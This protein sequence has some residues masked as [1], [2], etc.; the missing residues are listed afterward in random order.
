[1]SFYLETECPIDFSFDYQEIAQKVITYCLKRE[2][3]PYEAE[4]N[5]TLT[6]NEGI[7][8]IN[9]AY[10]DIDRPTD[11]LSF[12]MLSYDTPGDFSFLEEESDDNFN[13]DTGEAILGDI[14]ISVE[15]VKE[16][17]LEYGHSELRE[18]AFLI[19]HSMLHLFGYDH[20]EK[21]EADIM[22][23]LQKQILEE[24][25]ILR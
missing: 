20:M 21:E 17:A 9:K 5:L 25:Q 16:Q 1:M 11:V 22:E 13:P 14:I 2:K 23:N 6:D 8:Q 18:Y 12:P 7:W 4:V 24:L 19:T 3:F 15:K 10:R